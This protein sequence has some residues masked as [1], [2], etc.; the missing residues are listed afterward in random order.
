[1]TAKAR[2]PGRPAGSRNTDTQDRIIRCACELFARHGI[3]GTSNQMLAGKARV[4]PAMIH[5]YF[6]RRE[7]LYK[8]IM[9]HA[10]SFARDEL[11]QAQSLEQWV[12]IFHE[13]LIRNPWIPHLMIREVIP[14]G[15]K[16][17][18]YFLNHIGPSIFASIREQMISEAWSKNLGKD[19]DLE[20][21][22]VLL[23]GML[24]YP[25]IGREIVEK[26]TATKFN[27]GIMVK[28]REDALSLF[29][30]GVRARTSIEK[31]KASHE[32]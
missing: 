23:M 12:S 11:M 15:G 26:I 4:T 5:Y 9:E 3:K 28:F 6:K 21:H 24:V 29:E 22:I 16:L 31:R 2:Q 30:A 25:F 19:F 14:H 7:D 20:R 13:H 27:D 18:P 8:A 10:F 32:S 17:Q 1:M